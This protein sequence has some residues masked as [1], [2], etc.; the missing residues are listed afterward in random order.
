MASAQLDLV[1]SV[2]AAWVSGDFSETEW[3][4]PEIAF[5]IADGP[6]P[7]SWTGLADMAEG[8]RSFLS[9]WEEFQGENVEEYRE[10]DD[11]RILLFHSYRGRGKS[12][13]LDLGQIGA[14]AAT[15]FHVR[16]GKVV[17]LVLYFDRQR[18][19]DELGVAPDAG[20]TPRVQ[21]S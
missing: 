4:D 15:V 14:R 12:S 19:L 3:A 8:W 2:V 11:E 9:A 6:A 7:G 18:A 17:R 13:G 5:V 10:L 21:N 16:G 1:R 20:S